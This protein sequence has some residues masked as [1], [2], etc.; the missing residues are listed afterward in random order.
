VF[1]ACGTENA[2]SESS[3]GPLLAAGAVVV[4]EEAVVTAAL[5]ELAPA[6]LVDAADVVDAP[7]VVGA[8][9]EAAV[10]GA[11]VVA[12]LSLSDPHATSSSDPAS[13]SA[14]A[15]VLRVFIRFPSSSPVF[16]EPGGGA[17]GVCVVYVLMTI[18][19]KNVADASSVARHAPGEGG[20]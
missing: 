18:P 1:A 5:V 6:V 16:T 10:V 13:A 8:A 19:I 12:E 9:V 3:A 2:T 11:A 14:S 20:R 7:L 17:A 4:A 15:V